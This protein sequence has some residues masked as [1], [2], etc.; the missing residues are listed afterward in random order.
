MTL[1]PLTFDVLFQSMGGFLPVPFL[2]ALAYNESSLK[3]NAVTKSSNATGLF[4]VTQTVLD[5]Y[6]LQHGTKY[7]LEN[8]KD[9]TLNSKIGIELL[10]RIVRNY[11][12]NHPKSLAMNWQDPRFVSLVVQGFNAGYSEAAGVGF[13]VGNLERSGIPPEQITVD[14]VAEAAKK[15]KAS[16]FLYQPERVRYAK[17]VTGTYF[18][19]MNRDIAR[20]KNLP[21]VVPVAQ[22]PGTEGNFPEGAV[23]FTITPKGNPNEPAKGSFSK[24]KENSTKD[25][26]NNTLPT[27][28]D[29]LKSKVSNEP[30]VES[31]FG[32]TAFLLLFPF[33]PVVGFSLAS[34]FK[35]RR[36]TLRSM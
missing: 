32:N 33:V 13:V 34:A 10:T 1:I 16:R 36:K 28:A 6:N 4:Q 8:V 11:V 35:S 23:R 18:S 3:P 26:K 20:K 15:L 7:N 5:D 19:E 29:V 12:T 17:A 27:A 24:G 30:K 21:Q 25:S 22:V 9:P 14:T 31:D 2:R